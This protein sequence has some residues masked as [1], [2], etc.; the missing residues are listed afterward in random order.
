MTLAAYPAQ[1]I[2]NR[3]AQRGV[4]LITALLIIALVAMVAVALAARQQIDIRRSANIMDADQAYEL[5]L[6]VEMWAQGV[7]AA[8]LKGGATDSQHDDW[9]TVL[10]PIKAEGGKVAGVITDLQGRFNLNNLVQ[11]RQ[12]SDPDVKIFQRLLANLQLDPDLASAVVD[13]ID[14]DVERGF[15]NGAEDVDYLGLTPPYRTANAP[16]TSVSELLLVRG[17]TPLIYAK[18][19]PLVCALP[20]PTGIN[21]NTAPAAVLAALADDVSV[22]SAQALVEARKA[23]VFASVG[24]FAQQPLYAGRVLQQDKLAVASSYFLLAGSSEAGRG[25]VQLYSVLHR[26]TD[27]KVGVLMRGRGSL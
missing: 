21:V 5:A 13:W 14:P 12:R 26:S 16:M 6:G 25:Q 1:C 2:R 24:E 27:G 22:T 20:A 8:D 19:A 18:L 3:R 10:A 7:L 9:A 15:P 17:I 4:A 23:K 11:N